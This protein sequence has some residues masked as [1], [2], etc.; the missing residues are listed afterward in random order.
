MSEDISEDKAMQEVVTRFSYDHPAQTLWQLTGNFGGLKAWLPGVVDCTVSGAGAW[1]QGGNAERAVQL[2]D[3]SVTRESL[4]FLDEAGMRYGY[5]IL[6]M[7]GFKP[8]QHF[9]AEFAVTPLGDA[10]C[11]VVWCARF[12]VPEDWPADKVQ[13]A[14]ERVAQMYGF[15]LTHLNSVL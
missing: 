8:G 3:G 1:D 4:A 7:K 10:Q 5:A 15:F 13:Q 2:M 6:D 11:E 12:N 14:R 9:S